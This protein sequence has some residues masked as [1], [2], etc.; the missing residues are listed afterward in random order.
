MRESP[1]D[2][3][4]LQFGIAG[5]KMALGAYARTGW[6]SGWRR[7]SVVWMGALLI[8][9]CLE[10]AG[11][12][13]MPGAPST[14]FYFL[15]DAVL[16]VGLALFGIRPGVLRRAQRAVSGF[17]PVL[18]LA[19]AV[20]AV[21]ALN[22]SL[23]SPALAVI[24][25]RS[26]WLW[27]M[28]PLVIASALRMPEDRARAVTILSAL[29]LLVAGVAAIQFSFPP[30]AAINTYALYEGK[31]VLDVATVGATGKA[32]VSSTFS[33]LSGFVDFAILIPPLL[34]SLGI[35][36]TDRGKR[37]LR[38]VAAG[39]TAITLPMSG[40]RGPVLVGAGALVAVAWGA[41]FL[42]SQVG[43]RLILVGIL[44][45][46]A[47]AVAVPEATEGVRS[48]FAGEDTVHRISGVLTI[49]P[50]VALALSEYP[51]AGIGT[52]MQ[53]NA[54]AALGVR[55]DW[56]SE[57]EPERLLIELGPIGY[58]LVW[59]A[60]LGLIVALLRLARQFGREGR[61]GLSGAALAY[62]ILTMLGNLVFDHVWQAL[63][64]TGLG[65]ILQGAVSGGAG[66]GRAPNQADALRR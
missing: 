28:A 38:L 50:P 2:T 23:T 3:G 45:A 15:K 44:V 66:G 56:G 9:I 58:L 31:E 43:R 1:I 46:G 52:G 13:F 33:Y 54:R 37:W 64:F 61:R 19:F 5:Q 65:L 7:K 20:T 57:G 51:L 55:T 8:A 39:A 63:Y 59:M 4:Q 53:Q 40:S 21:E 18:V 14:L 60:K 32:R 42:R 26:Y 6:L 35:G 47:A 34:L 30:E 49:L 12:K 27:W 22:A 48:R 11:R 16:L 29:A 36:E 25:F 41:G 10:G 17:A 62:A 24:G